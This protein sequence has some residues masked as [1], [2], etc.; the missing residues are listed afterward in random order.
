VSVA[1]VPVAVEL[2]AASLVE[3]D[4]LSVSVPVLESVVTGVSDV[5]EPPDVSEVLRPVLSA[6]AVDVAVLSIVAPPDV[7]AVDVPVA[8]SEVRLVPELRPV[9]VVLLGVP[10]PSLVLC[11]AASSALC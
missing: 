6:V 1:P 11:A 5:L 8:V 9:P 10:V 3:A 2:P 7:P 4:V